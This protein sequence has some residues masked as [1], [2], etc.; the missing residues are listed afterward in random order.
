MYAPVAVSRTA[1]DQTP[2]LVGSDRFVP[3]IWH[4]GEQLYGDLGMDVES[5]VELPWGWDDIKNL[6]R[7][8]WWHPLQLFQFYEFEWTVQQNWSLDTYLR[9]VGSGFLDWERHQRIQA[10]ETLTEKANSDESVQ[11]RRILALLLLVEPIVHGVV[12]GRIGYG[13]N[14]SI[15]QYYAWREQL[16]A[17]DLLQQV[18][19]SRE[20]AIEWHEKFSIR[21]SLR[22][23]L[24]GLR[25]LANQVSPERRFAM[26]GE[27]LRAHTM[28]DHAEI[29]RRYIEWKG[30][31]QLY[32]EDDY[33]MREGHQRFKEE[34]FGCK[35]VFDGRRDVLRRINRYYGIDHAER[36]ALLLEGPTEFAF[37]E[38][39]AELWGVDLDSRGIA[40]Y[41]LGGKDAIGKDR[42][43]S[44]Y[45]HVL[46]RHEVFAFAALDDDGG[47]D[48][49]R[50]LTRLASEGL[51][52]AGF[53]IWTPDF[54]SH[55]FSLEE[56]A[57]AATSISQQHGMEVEFRADELQELMA[58]SS[59]PAGKALERLASQK[60]AYT[61]K[62]AAWGRALADVVIANESA[63]PE[64]IRDENGDR[65]AIAVLQLIIRAESADYQLSLEHT[66]TQ[67]EAG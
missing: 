2:G 55:N 29:L 46:A 36:I 5:V 57:Q 23:P 3:T 65:P 60:R 10:R 30:D 33:N 45:L 53:K 52:S 25:I 4:D 6:S 7:S 54:E 21:A 47:G 44:Q 37:Y 27:V 51:L 12:H 40:L 38:R 9:D 18:G 16:M 56:L 35:R 15:E 19:L 28:F 64:G 63:V 39:L 11:F 26:Q 20:Q 67:Q 49:L 31:E 62:G 17:E 41:Q 24:R 32:E 1:I 50:S 34:W 42:M 22:D 66:K 43:L 59:L 14:E 8:L 58:R 13:L 48:H 61:L